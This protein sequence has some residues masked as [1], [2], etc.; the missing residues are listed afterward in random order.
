MAQTLEATPT[1]SYQGRR[2]FNARAQAQMQCWQ[3]TIE[4]YHEIALVAERNER[5]G[6]AIEKMQHQLSQA[7][8]H[9]AE[10]GNPS[11]NAWAAYR[12][13]LRRLRKAFEEAR[14]AACEEFQHV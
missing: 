9:F 10:I 7:K 13:S 12:E 5:L 11:S 4:K 1:K 14:K 8:A 3:E 6:A 2:E